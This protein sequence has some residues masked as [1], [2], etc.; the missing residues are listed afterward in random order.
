MFRY[1]N[2]GKMGSRVGETLRL[3]L[4]GKTVYVLKIAGLQ[5]GIP[6]NRLH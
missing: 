1:Q 2:K 3:R 5:F 4:I 6:E